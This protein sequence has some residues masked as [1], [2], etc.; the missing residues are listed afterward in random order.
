MKKYIDRITPQVG[1]AWCA[2]EVYTK[3]RGNL[4]YLFALCDDET[5]YWIAKG[6]ADR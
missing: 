3:V 5:R 4:K 6:V 2:D 1:D